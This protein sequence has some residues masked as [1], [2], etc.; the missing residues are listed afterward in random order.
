MSNL[1]RLQPQRLTL[2]GFID[3][4]IAD[5]AEGDTTV[6]MFALVHIIGQSEDEVYTT[7]YNGSKTSAELGNTFQ[8][9][10]NYRAQDGDGIQTFALLAFYGDSTT[11]NAKHPFIVNSLELN[12]PRGIAT[13]GPTSTGQVQQGMRH[14]EM[15]VQQAYKA[16]HELN[17][18]YQAQI[19]LLTQDAHNLRQENMDLANMAKDMMVKMAA[20]R[21]EEELAKINAARAAA[22]E[23]Q[24]M[25]MIPPLANQLSGK[26]VFPES[27]A[28][29]ALFKAIAQ[30]LIAAPP[31]VVM[32]LM[33]NLNLPSELGAALMSRITQLQEEAAKVALE[34]AQ[35][36]ADD[37]L[38]SD[39]QAKELS[40]GE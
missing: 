10:A 14:A 28:D 36:P 4:C 17:N 26:Q 29:G 37:E 23:Q 18:S 33:G 39:T 7:K 1:A 15:V 24:L 9:R 11:P 21:H 8:K 30:H 25:A 13:E 34:Q 27:N 40:H 16:Q 32:Q 35:N 20:M 5:A 31:G 22:R 3:Q 6:N 19:R 38:G 2:A 12:A